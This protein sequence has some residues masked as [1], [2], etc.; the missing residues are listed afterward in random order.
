METSQVDEHGRSALHYCCDQSNLDGARVLLED[1]STSDQI[2]DRQD[3]EGCSA[4]HL[5]KLNR[6]SSL[7]PLIIY[8]SLYERKWR[9][10]ESFM[11]ARRRRA[12]SR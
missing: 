3:R 5:G 8:D 4:L 7:H 9:S 6:R 12:I 1:K 2:L 10:G 11:R